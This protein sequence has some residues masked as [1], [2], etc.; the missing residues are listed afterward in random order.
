MAISCTRTVWVR[1]YS[2]S[3]REPMVVRMRLS[4][5]R[6]ICWAGAFLTRSARPEM[7]CCSCSVIWCLL[8][9][10]EDRSQFVPWRRLYWSLNQSMKTAFLFP[11]QG[12]QYA[13]MGRSL[14]EAFPAARACFE[15]AD[16]ALGF[17]LSKLCFEGPDEDLK[18]TENTQ[19]A[20]LAVSIAAYTVLK[21]LAGAP[22][23][24]A[25]HSVGEY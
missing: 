10:Y 14:A 7:S 9:W 3:G 1:M 16:E 23:Y 25:G 5:S 8:L 17:P 21:S 6:S 20:L 22:D 2:A 19:P 24:V 11:G 18:Q 12:S 15:T 4:A 13:G